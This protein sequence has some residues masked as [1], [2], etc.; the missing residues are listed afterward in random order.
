MW[1]DKINKMLLSITILSL[2]LSYL[3]HSIVYYYY[4]SNKKLQLTILISSKLLYD[5][6]DAPCYSNCSNCYSFTVFFKIWVRH[7]LLRAVVWGKIRIISL[8]IKTF[9][10]FLINLLWITAFI[11]KFS[12][13]CRIQMTSSCSSNGKAL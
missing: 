8:A 13:W 3:Y 7:L 9:S 4:D 6:N 2:S 1:N 10:N 12:Q 11:S 5:I